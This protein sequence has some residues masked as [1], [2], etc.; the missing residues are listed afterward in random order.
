[1]EK[2]NILIWIK[3]IICF[4][5]QLYNK[6]NLSKITNIWI[7]HVTDMFILILYDI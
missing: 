1:M 5:K 4:E 3:G 2:K 7:Y 6:I